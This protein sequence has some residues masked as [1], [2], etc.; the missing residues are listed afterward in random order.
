MQAL[1][2]GA[3]IIM[4]SDTDSHHHY[5]RFGWKLVGLEGETLVEGID[6]GELGPDGRLQKIVGFFG[7]LPP[8]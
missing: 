5:V 2:P 4:T 1:R 3:R 7:P 6:F 8:S